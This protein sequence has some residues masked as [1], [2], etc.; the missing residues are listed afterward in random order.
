MHDYVVTILQMP[1]ALIPEVE[2]DS[3]IGF[4]EPVDGAVLTDCHIV[5]DPGGSSPGDDE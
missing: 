3:G 4:F 1:C 2:I 5:T